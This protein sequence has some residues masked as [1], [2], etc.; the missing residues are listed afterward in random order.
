[1]NRMK[2]AGFACA[3]TLA[4]PV[5]LMLGS[6][7]TGAATPAQKCGSLKGS[8]TLSPGLTTTP[9]TQTVTAN[10]TLASCTPSAK[11][12]GGGTMHAT[13]TLKNASC[14]GLA[15]GTTISGLKGSIKWKNGKTSAVT[16]NAKTTSSAPTTATLTGKVSSGL[17]AGAP[18]SGK[19]TFTVKSGQNCSPAAPVKNLTYVNKDQNGKVVPFVI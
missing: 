12:G 18:I 10:G 16:F 19:I 9:S 11:T 6:S 17:F 4:A 14:T 2:I 8:A 5:G 7:A 3:L 15:S 13:S 1:M